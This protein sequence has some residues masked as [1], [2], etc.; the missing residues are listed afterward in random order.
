[1]TSVAGNRYPF[2]LPLEP[3]IRPEQDIESRGNLVASHYDSLPPSGPAFWEAREVDVRER[4][5]IA[6]V[7][8]GNYVFRQPSDAGGWLRD[9][10]ANPEVYY[11][12]PSFNG[13][14]A[15]VTGGFDCGLNHDALMKL[16]GDWGFG[17]V[18]GLEPDEYFYRVKL[19]GPHFSQKERTDYCIRECQSPAAVVTIPDRVTDYDKLAEQMGVYRNERVIHIASA[20]DPPEILVARR[21][22]ACSDAHCIVVSIFRDRLGRIYIAAAPFSHFAHVSGAP[23]TVGLPGRPRF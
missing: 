13:Y 5:L 1:M 17:I 21:I 9:R 3:G 20:D 23:P 18:L 11:S 4:P 15:Y 7:P 2:R 12:P 6:D 14:F 10:L 19:R 8:K 22:R 16:L